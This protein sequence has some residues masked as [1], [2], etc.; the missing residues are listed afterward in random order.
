MISSNN[1]SRSCMRAGGV[2]SWED[3]SFF[4][5]YFVAQLFFSGS[6]WN[7]KTNSLKLFKKSIMQIRTFIWR[8]DGQQSWKAIHIIFCPLFKVKA[9]GRFFFFRKINSTL[10]LLN[11]GIIVYGRFRTIY[12]QRLTLNCAAICDFEQ[13]IE[14][15]WVAVLKKKEN[16]KLLFPTKKKQSDNYLLI[17]NSF[18]FAASILN[19]IVK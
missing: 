6:I 12:H 3:F 19:A 8:M 5:W 10:L 4:P 7:L 16:R 14:D 11:G 18:L 15:E 9:K 13:K 17:K 2:P 1:W